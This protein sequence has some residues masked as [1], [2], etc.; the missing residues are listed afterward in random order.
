MEANSKEVDVKVLDTFQP[1]DTPEHSGEASFHPSRTRNH[2][3]FNTTPIKP[4]SQ[5]NFDG[6]DV[7]NEVLFF[8]YTLCL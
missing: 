8:S 2:S 7:S 6:D 5:P 4:L 1:V 3:S